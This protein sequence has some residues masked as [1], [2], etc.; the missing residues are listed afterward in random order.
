MLSVTAVNRDAEGILDGMD[1]AGT[2]LKVAVNAL[3][4]SMYTNGYISEN[5]N[6]V[7]VSVKSD[8]QER[9]KRLNRNC[10][11][12]WKMLWQTNR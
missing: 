10:L 2:D 8:S 3:I 6:S 1:L 11:L 7:L 9:A 5:Q 4:G 12:M